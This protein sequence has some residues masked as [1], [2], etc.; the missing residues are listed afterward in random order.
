MDIQKKIAFF[1]EKQFP[2]VYREYGS[3][4][5]TLVE[6]YYRFLE[7]SPNQSHY[8]NRRLFE[9]KDISTTLNS[10]LIFYKNKYLKDLPLDESNVKFLVKNILDLYRRK[11]TPEGIILF[12]RLFFQEDVEIYY[13][14]QQILKP[15]SSTWQ[16]G[17]FLQMEYNNNVF[18]DI[19]GNTFSYVDLPGRN[20]KGSLSG[21][22]A[23]VSNVNLMII[24]GV[25][26][27]ILYIDSVRGKF[28]RYDDVTAKIG[29]N[30]VNFGR[31]SGSLSGFNINETGGRTGNKKGDIFDVVS[32]TGTSGRALV[33]A[34]SDNP[35]GEVS[36]NV[37]DGG[38]GY[39]V[40]NTVLEV[41]NQSIILENSER[42]FIIGETISDTLGNTGK[43]VGQNDGSV[44]ILMDGSDEFIFG[45]NH[46]AIDRPGLPSPRIE[47]LGTSFSEVTSIPDRNDTS[48]G[49]M[50]ADTGLSTDVKVSSL[51][52]IETVQ[53]ITDTISPHLATVLNIADWEANAPF[54]GTA[55]PV[56][57]AT[58]ISDAFDLTPFQVGSINSFS[59]LDPGTGYVNDVFALAKDPTMINFDRYNQI[60][61]IDPPA[62]ASIVS[63][64][65][66]ITE[67]VPSTSYFGRVVSTDST[68]G[69]ITITP[70]VYYG[71]S[72]TEITTSAGEKLVVTGISTDYTSKKV[73]SNATVNADTD[74][75]TGRVESVSIYNSGF[76]YQHQAD[77]S[78]V[79]D[80]GITIAR[81]QINVDSQGVTSGYWADFTSHL[82]GYQ[83]NSTTP[84][85]LILPNSNFS[86]AILAISAGTDP[87]TQVAS[88]DPLFE[89]WVQ[90]IASDGFPM[91]DLE[92]DGLQ[93]SAYDASRWELLAENGASAG[94]V[95][96]WN[97]II[98]PSLKSQ[99]WYSS[100]QGV[101]WTNSDIV[102]IY[103]Q[104]YYDSG[105]KVQDS[106]YYQEYSY[107]IK[108][109]IPQS[110]YETVLKENVH[111]AGSKQFSQ[112]YF[113]YKNDSTLEQDFIRVFNDDG[114]G[115]P[116]DQAILNNLSMDAT[117]LSVDSTEVRADNVP[118]I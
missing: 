9:Y 100:Q 19:D 83:V 30:I 62:A 18:T 35:T 110:Q 55:S 51:N 103:D 48:P 65:E 81:G 109:T 47:N 17:T 85:Q 61:K 113:R 26:V 98:V 25:K 97:N 29:S 41:S 101:I 63:V 91:Y 118:T 7:D 53:L 73:G 11:G 114:K 107:E 88:L 20:I 67:T 14:A 33:T 92:K 94:I 49:D 87:T 66:L 99:P 56:S 31:I 38:W 79:N 70:Y 6:E 74:F 3:E 69:T 1:I 43:V 16:T 22:R 115:T 34:V 45:R 12:F 77:A 8:N 104:K 86:T 95:N 106:D 93:I 68:A 64:G 44:G 52:F 39:T 10:M 5:V 112:F 105:M 108:S 116:L 102:N 96:R 75:A 89:T 54:S 58:V 27:A 36:Y 76:G 82:N 46:Y 57:L 24:N 23:A 80:D 71:F 90:T 40:E 50:F 84:T 111:L 28:I 117:N 21:A 15:S 2:A 78:L 4:L 72:S 60:L 42:V 13:P 32:G 37:T 59:N